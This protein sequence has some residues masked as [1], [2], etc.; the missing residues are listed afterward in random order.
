VQH[1]RQLIESEK[2]AGMQFTSYSGDRCCTG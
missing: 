2:H 1:I